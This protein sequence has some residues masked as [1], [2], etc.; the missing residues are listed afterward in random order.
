MR[1]SQRI[2]IQRAETRSKLNAAITKANA[3]EANPEAETEM[4]TLTESL[5]GLDTRYAA[6]VKAEAA[7]DQSDA[8]SL[9]QDL[10][11]RREVR[12]LEGRARLSGFV[13][14][15]L[16]GTPATGAD[17][18][19][20]AAILGDRDAPNTVPLAL[21]DPG[22]EQRT[23]QRAD[24]VTP[25]AE[26]AVPDGSRAAMLDRIFKQSIA[27]RLGVTM[28]SVATGDA[29][30]PVMTA[31]TSA[32][33]KERDAAIEAGAAAFEAVSL[34]PVR[35]T[36]R[37]LFRLEDAARLPALESILRRDI[38]RAMSDE[39][40]VQI[41]SG[42]GTA[43]NVRGFLAELPAITDPSDVV[44]FAAWLAEFLGHVDGTNAYNLSDLRAIVGPETFRK[45]S[46][47]FSGVAGNPEASAYEYVSSRMGGMSVSSRLPAAASQVQTGIVAL[48]GYPGANAV[49]PVW[50]SF[51]LIR[52]PY[53]DA[54]KGRVSLTAV[55]LW[56]FKIVREGG[57]S[58]F[59]AKLA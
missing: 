51:H 35:L 56:N 13:R 5:A 47:T 42:D 57:W 38:S 46:A 11:E 28:R 32:A 53:S 31:G 14:E 15:A 4:G 29:V 16:D 9:P 10:G 6:A 17:A 49:A 55:A 30:F 39:M 23:E 43:P 54:A 18:E 21:L 44:T 50:D 1:L 3:G 22:P 36:A 20:R 2:D 40:D 26:T 12:S 24:A 27:G 34:D 58:L 48:T 8:G 59:K 33:M 19:Y 41:V 25:V 52:D 45:V 37:Y 7:A